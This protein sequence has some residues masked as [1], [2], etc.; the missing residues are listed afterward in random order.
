MLN[1]YSG[2][3]GGGGGGGGAELHAHAY[4]RMGNFTFSP[5]HPAV[6]TDDVYI[7]G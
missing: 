3:G 5:S 7:L 1:N 2:G 4:G 6:T